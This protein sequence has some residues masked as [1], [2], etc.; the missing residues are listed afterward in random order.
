MNRHQNHLQLRLADAATGSSTLLHEEQDKAYIDIDDDL[1]FLKDNSFIWSS[2]QNGYNHIYHYSA[3]GKLKK[4]ITKGSWD[5][6][7]FYGIDEKSKTL[8]YQSAEEAP[9][10][11]AIYTVK[12]NGKDKKK[13]S[14]RKGHNDAEF[15]KG[16]QYYINTHTDANTPNYISLH[17]SNGQEIRVLKDNSTLVERINGYTIK[18]KEFFTFTTSEGVQLNGWMI[19]PADFDENKRYPVLMYVYGGPG[20]QTVEDSWGGFNTFWYHMLAQEGY[21]VVSIDNRGTGARGRDFKKITYQQLGKYETMDQI[22]GARY[23]GTLPFVDKDRIGIWGWSYGGYMSSL[24]LSKGADVFKMAIAVAPVTNWRFYDSIYTE[25]Y[26]RTPQENASGY[27]DN[28]P[29]NHVNKIKG[30]YLLIHAPQMTM[31]MYKTPTV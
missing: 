27:D 25:R 21:I 2:E 8:Y 20:S 30:K 15:S 10:N 11:R 29:I 31:Y 1:T 17:Q 19:K 14:Q 22:E 23:M 26:M 7:Q 5:V 6:T 3:K 13:L 24:C 16:F 9:M 4:Q 18:P 28:S 12:L